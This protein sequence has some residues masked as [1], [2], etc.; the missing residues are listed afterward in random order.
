M[1]LLEANHGVFLTAREHLCM[2]PLKNSRLFPKLV[3]R[4]FT[5]DLTG[6]FKQTVFSGVIIVICRQ[7]TGKCYEQDIDLHMLFMDFRQAFD[8]VRRVK[9]YESMRDMGT[10]CRL[11]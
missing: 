5:L 3:S 6:R 9:H 8:S 7:I 2:K 4:K 11:L 10:L 1:S